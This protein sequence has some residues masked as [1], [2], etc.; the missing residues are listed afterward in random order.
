M[1]PDDYAELKEGISEQVQEYCELLID[2]LKDSKCCSDSSKQ[3]HESLFDMFGESLCCRDE[4]DAYVSANTDSSESSL[5]RCDALDNYHE[6]F[7]FLGAPPARS[8]NRDREG[9][10]FTMSASCYEL[11]RRYLRMF[12]STQPS[13]DAWHRVSSLLLPTIPISE[14]RTQYAKF[15]SGMGIKPILLNFPSRWS[16][17]EDYVLVSMIQSRGRGP[18][19]IHAIFLALDETRSYDDIV[20]R[21]LVFY[22]KV[23][24]RYKKRT[25]SETKDEDFISTREPSSESSA[26]DWSVDNSLLDIQ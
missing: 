14:L 26:S 22:P 15:Q 18:D 8:A 24:K 4:L 5:M 12:G 9:S 21:I 19:A 25:K 3:L 6:V 11:I 1:R 2:L 16:F 10:A 13:P 23:V 7:Q 17:D 20:S